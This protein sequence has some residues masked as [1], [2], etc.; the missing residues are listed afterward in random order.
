MKIRDL[1]ADQSRGA[2]R[3]GTV[4]A[5]CTVFPAIAIAVVVALNTFW[6]CPEGGCSL[7]SWTEKSKLLTNVMGLVVLMV[8]FSL[9]LQF[10]FVLL[11]RPFCRREIVEEAFLK[12]SLPWLAWHDALMR[13]WVAML[14]RPQQ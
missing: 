14:W 2:R 7:T 9:F 3:L 6:W 8:F 11:T 13:K 4:A 1:I 5:I 10:P 12:H